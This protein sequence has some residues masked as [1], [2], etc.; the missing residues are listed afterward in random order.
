MQNEVVGM[1][2]VEINP[3]LDHSGETMMLA[4]RVVREVLVGMALRK[5]GMTDPKYLHPDYV[6]NTQLKQ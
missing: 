1:D 4:N 6:K 2:V 3:M 5:K